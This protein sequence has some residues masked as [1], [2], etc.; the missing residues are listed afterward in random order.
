MST[1]VGDIME[2]YEQ[3]RRELARKEEQNYPYGKLDYIQVQGDPNLYYA[4]IPEPE[5][6]PLN[7]MFDHFLTTVHSLEQQ[8]G[9]NPELGG[10]LILDYLVDGH[11]VVARREDGERPIKVAWQR[12][13][14]TSKQNGE[15]DF[16]SEN[17]IANGPKM[18]MHYTTL[19]ID[20][21]NFERRSFPEIAIYEDPTHLSDVARALVRALL[22]H[23]VKGDQI[24]QGLRS[25][26]AGF[27]TNQIGGLKIYQEY[28][29]GWNI[30]LE[31]SKISVFTLINLVESAV[32]SPQ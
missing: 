11:I 20:L 18:V 14:R 15:Y 9:N 22:S 12:W 10:N 19:L 31:G 21:D 28:L 6:T 29:G 7:E 5:P 24:V 1:S 30:K 23:H 25:K 3:E 26:L 4:V 27:N 8:H 13:C 32:S 17:S 2:L 16:H